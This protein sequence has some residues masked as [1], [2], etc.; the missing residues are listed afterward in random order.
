VLPEVPVVF[1]TVDLHF[2]RE[3]RRLDLGDAG[4]GSKGVLATRELELALIRSADSTIVVSEHE[5]T[6]LSTITP[7]AKIF[8][9]PTVHDSSPAAGRAGRLDISFVGSYQHDPNADALRW[10]I[11]EIFPIVRSLMPRA[12]LVVVGKNPPL[13][14]VEAAPIGVQFLGWVEDLVPVYSSSVVSIA[15]LRYGAGVKGKVGEAWAH[16]VPV[17]MT[18]LAAEGM[19]VEPGV[20]ALIADDARSFAEAIV[21]LMKD[22]RLWQ[23]IAEAGRAHVDATFGT[24]VF[25]RSLSA[26]IGDSVGRS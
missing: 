23:R 19:S 7:E 10:F 8:V 24:D 17:V 1:D 21:A 4:G 22:E 26:I 16:G 13:D 15:P 6:V 11:D 12:R 2:L 3:Q 25:R 14:I 20:T 9:L 5:R 18:S